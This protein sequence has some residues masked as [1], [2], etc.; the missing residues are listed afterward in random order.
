MA[1]ILRKLPASGATAALGLLLVV[2]IAVPI[3]MVLFESVRLAGPIPLH[4]LARITEKALSRLEP[5]DRQQQM[6]RWL[7]SLKPEE[8]TATIAA[9]LEL[10]GRRV[11][12]DTKALFDEQAAAAAAAMAELSAADRQRF[13]AIYPLAA[14]TLYK[15]IPLAFRLRDKLTPAEFDRLR[16][17]TQRGYG[18]DHYVDVFASARL[19]R[20][21]RNSLTLSAVVA[22]LATVIGFAVAY[23]INRRAIAMPHLVRYLTLIPLVSPPVV[24][25]TAAILL[26]GRNGTITKGLLQDTL[27]WINA[28]VTNLYGWG[29]VILAQVL[30]HIPHAFIL[31]DN[32]LSKHDGRLEEAAASQGASAWQVFTRITLPMS[33]PGVVRSLILV[34]MLIMTDFGNPLV[35]GKNIPVLAGILYDEMTAFQNTS[36][37]AALAVWM[38]LPALSVYVLIERLGRRK[39]FV[40]GLGAPPELPVPRVA[41]AALTAVAWSAVGLTMALYGTIVY[42][43]FVKIWRVD[44]S[45]TLAWYTTGGV[46]G[47]VSEYRGVSVVWD[48]VKVAALAAPLGG[49]LAVALAY[50]IERT[51]PLG[52]NLLGFIPL[53]PAILPG[54]ILGVGY[55]VAFNFPFGMKSLALTSTMWILVV[56]ILFANIFVGYLAG[57]AV[58]QRYDAAIDEAAESLGASLWQRFA[59]VTLPIMRHALV[60]GALYVFVSGL[61][62]LSAVIF[63]V[64]PQHKLAS[65]AIFD[66]AEAGHY[67]AASAMSVTIL[68]IVF[69]VMGVNHWFERRGP[70]WG[71]VGAMAAGR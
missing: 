45:F 17:G 20:A 58:L 70:G 66:A 61:T 35:I 40:S 1:A 57:R 36:L 64:S 5:G 16:E 63:L 49:L 60:L 24:I 39:R 62:T 51:R 25:A 47:F 41:R 15:R 11:P 69:A 42:A 68:L 19:H 55:V 34:F 31:L 48:S 33:Q 50:L 27:G 32:V 8:R 3:G 14:V 56:N 9:G 52:G 22:V 29:G 10:M 26:F 7:A 30:G 2:F 38:I 4:D 21:F 44:P 65:V 18:L 12:W 37:A 54:V 53:L 28:D 59:W 6:A 23:G 43:S 46:A 67:G 71:R 13:D